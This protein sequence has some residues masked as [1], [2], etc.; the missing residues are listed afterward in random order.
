MPASSSVSTATGRPSLRRIWAAALAARLSS[1]SQSSLD[2]PL[3][4][5]LPPLRDVAIDET[6]SD[7]VWHHVMF[8]QGGGLAAWGTASP[9]VAASRGRMAQ[10]AQ[11]P[12]H[13]AREGR[14]EDE[15]GREAAVLGIRSRTGAGA[16]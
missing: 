15:A 14:G 4:T 13:A 8:V 12:H 9:R 5:A 2:G 10:P 3:G 6:E 1:A 16:D 11:S 7:G